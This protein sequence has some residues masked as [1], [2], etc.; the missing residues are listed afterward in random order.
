M[1]EQLKAPERENRKPHQANAILRNAAAY[2][3][4]ADLDRGSQ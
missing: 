3:A 2:V 4:M 1:A